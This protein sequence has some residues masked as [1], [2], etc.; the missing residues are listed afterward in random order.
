MWRLIF[1]LIVTPALA[2]V[3][4]IEEVE[5]ET[6]EPY[7]SY[8]L[9]KMVERAILE[10]G[11]KLSCKNGS[12]RV[13][14]SIRDFRETPLAYS[15]S[16]RVSSYILSLYFEVSVK[17]NSFSVSG[18]VPYSLPTGGLGDLP[19]RKAIDDL[20]DKIYFEVLKNFRRLE[21]ADKG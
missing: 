7:L 14:I 3:F 10:S 2:G 5:N 15:P 4:C 11:G 8:A 21:D 17:E 12:D 19:R 13:R 6:N 16:Q 1:S 18:S 20:V 9:L